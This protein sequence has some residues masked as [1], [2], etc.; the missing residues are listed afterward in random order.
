MLAKSP[1]N[2]YSIASTIE[3]TIPG[4]RHALRRM[5]A[6]GWVRL[7]DKVIS[8]GRQER[9]YQLTDLGEQQLRHELIRLSELLELGEHHLAVRSAMMNQ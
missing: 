3:A 4:V 7:S 2:S 8:T 1:G 9:T 5:E 6:K